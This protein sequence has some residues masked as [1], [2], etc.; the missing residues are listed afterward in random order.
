MT[1]IDRETANVTFI[2]NQGSTFNPTIT[3]KDSGGNPVDLTGYS[4]RMQIRRHVRASTTIASLTDSAGDITLGGAAGTIKPVISATDT[5]AFDFDEA[6][7]DLELEDASGV[8]TRLLDGSIVL[9]R[10]VT[11]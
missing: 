11:R 2:I 9:R 7:Y 3:W 5:A 6:V 1:T 8:V 4:A 10:E